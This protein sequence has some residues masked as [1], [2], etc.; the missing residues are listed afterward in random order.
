MYSKKLMEAPPESYIFGNLLTFENT[1]KLLIWNKCH[2]KWFHYKYVLAESY[3]LN[4]FYA[5]V[6]YII[7]K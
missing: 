4:N 5:I 1:S 6:L 2:L 3:V 7:L